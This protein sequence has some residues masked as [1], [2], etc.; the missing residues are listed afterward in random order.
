[1][2]I[3]IGAG[4]VLLACNVQLFDEPGGA[5]FASHAFRTS[6]H[7]RVTPET[8]RKTPTW[9]GLAENPPLSAR[10]ALRAADK[11]KDELVKD[12]DE[13][14]WRLRSLNLRGRGR[15]WYWVAHYR[16]LPRQGGPSSHSGWELQLAVLMD[17]TAVKPD[18]KAWR[19][20]K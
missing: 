16:P 6:Y 9:G 13:Y 19:K 15:W 7:T 5:N 11:M 4:L 17:G 18:V 12:T 8:M 14:E 2:L 3:A 20:A 10:D 1:M